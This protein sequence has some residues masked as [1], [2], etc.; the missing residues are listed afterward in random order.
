MA[1][2][3]VVAELAAVRVCLTE[4]VEA[5]GSLVPKGEL[6]AASDV[7]VEDNRRW[8]RSIALLILGGP[9][10]FLL[11]LGIF[12]QTKANE[13]T[14]K[15]DVRDGFTC[16]LG[17][18]SAHRHDQRI[19]ETAIAAKLGIDLELGP[20]TNIPDEDR[21]TLTTACPAVLRRFADLS[22]GGQRSMNEAGGTP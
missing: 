11:N 20:P 18:E 7:V 9:V 2:E 3:E 1:T 12:F 6:A 4:V 13:A 19:F 14:F 5:I 15:A 10:L 8:R 22:L 16:L 17:D 21:A